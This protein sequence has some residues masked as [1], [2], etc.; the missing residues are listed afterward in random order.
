[1]RAA[2]IS[3]VIA[4]LN[5]AAAVGALLEALRA[6]TLLPDEVLFADGG[7]TDETRAVIAHCSS[8]LPFPVRVLH[9]PGKIA[10]GRNAAIEASAYPFIA[11]I[12]ADCMPSAVWLQALCEPLTAG[13]RAVAGAYR[14]DAHTPMQRAI[15]TFTWVPL[16]DDPRRCLPS[17]RSVAF[18]RALWREIGGYNEEIDSGE[19]TL[20]DLEVRKRCG[21][22][23]APQA[24]VTWSPRKTLRSAIRQQVFYGGGDGNARSQASYHAAIAA[25]VAAECCLFVPGMRFAGALAF[26]A[27]YLYF[28]RKHALLFRKLF[29]DALFVA[30]LTIVLPVARLAGY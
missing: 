12:D 24:L 26:T 20:F 16:P 1:M 28:L 30:L 15:G 8:A 19:D 27:A 7:S 29:P 18:E 6:Q 4:V 23:L 22:A 14:A 21:F 17:H 2:G 10:A 9:V 11:V 5:E 13:A 25:F 3:V